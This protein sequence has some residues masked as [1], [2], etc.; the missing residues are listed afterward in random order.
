MSWLTDL[1]FSLLSLLILS[2]CDVAGQFLVSDHSTEYHHG[3]GKS[4]EG[5]D[6][7]HL[8]NTYHRKAS[9]PVFIRWE[10]GPGYF[11]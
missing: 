5:E 2:I 6:S 7:E 4:V 3:P 9:T 8:R 1:H 11:I 10:F